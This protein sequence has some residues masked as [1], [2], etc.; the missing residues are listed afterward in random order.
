MNMVVV[1]EY[2]TDG[3]FI[4]SRPIFKWVYHW[5]AGS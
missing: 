5:Q 1:T 3:C 2:F 4:Y